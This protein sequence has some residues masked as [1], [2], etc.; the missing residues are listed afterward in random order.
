MSG[1]GFWVTMPWNEHVHGSGD[2]LSDG[3]M[4]M[5]PNDMMSLVTVPW[6]IEVT[7][8]VETCWVVGFDMAYWDI[9][10]KGSVTFVPS[11]SVPPLAVS[12]RLPIFG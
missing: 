2:N 3:E 11:Y 4:D 7:Y 12:D 8:G 10:R 1:F 5:E 9:E 6:Q